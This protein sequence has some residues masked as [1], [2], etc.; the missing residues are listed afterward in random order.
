MNR[1]DLPARADAV[2]GDNQPPPLVDV[3]LL[4]SDAPLRE[5]LDRHRAGWAKAELHAFG[6][7][8]MTAHWQEQARL[9]NRFGPE[10]RTHDRA[11]QRSDQVDFH[12]A[13]HALMQLA[14]EQ[15]LHNR[16]WAEQRIGSHVTRS[17]ATLLY[18]QLESGTQ[19]P[20]T[21]THAAIPVLERHAEEWPELLET[22]L[23]RLMTRGYD[24]RFA[25]I[26]SKT[27][28]LI[29]MGMTERTGGSDVRANR[30][31]AVAIGARG[32]GERYRLNGHKWFMSAPMCDAFLVLAQAPGGLSCF[33][34][35]RFVGER[36]NGLHFQ[37][38]KDKLGN[39]SNASS[40]VEF[41]DAEAI[42]LGDEGR[43]VPVII[44]MVN[45]TRL[46]CML[47]ST[48]TMRQ[49]LLQAL[50]HA[51][52]RSAFGRKLVE[53]ALMRNVLADLALESE[54]ATALALRLAAA[55]DAG[56]DPRE[57]ALLRLMVPAAKFWVCKRL[58]SFVQEAMEVLGG[59][60]YVEDSVLPRLY[61]EAP[62][63]SIW[64]G[65]GNVMCLDVLRVLARD[66]GAREALLAELTA[67]RGR[68]L[69]FDRCLAAVPA[70]LAA[71]A[72]D[73]SQ[74]RR[75][76]GSL[77]L[78]VQ[79][80]LL[81]RYAPAVVAETFCAS[82]LTREIPAAPAAFGQLAAGSALERLIERAWPA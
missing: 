67:A 13:W 45:A 64:E 78:L 77:V 33:F 9:A 32:P 74:A 48:A 23:P 44:E 15:G 8:L 65:S 68:E 14:C 66:S 70:L 80:A 61:R 4:D 34:L 17:A 2:A 29:G 60:G 54:A 39:R 6:S 40:E 36:K 50:H 51:R 31:G 81:L 30:T 57:A 42:L 82:R 43:G 52:H 71:A 72:E 11:G 49:A 19:C 37:R 56:A 10:L 75:L 18:G 38:L 69:H 35:P 79:A 63:N 41:H 24:P 28:A 59:N 12:P 47:G 26:G 16:P 25:P 1:L 5:G 20:L 46:D 21:M 55:C 7:V 27:A 62:L 73:E 3:N 76:A 53:H 22:W 58:A